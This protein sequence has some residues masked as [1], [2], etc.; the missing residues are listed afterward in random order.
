MRAFSA[1]LLLL[2]GYCN[3]VRGAPPSDVETTLRREVKSYRLSGVASIEALTRAASE[4]KIP[5]GIE[6]FDADGAKQVNVSLDKTT[7]R[8]LVR[9]I[10]DSIG[11]YEMRPDGDILHIYP[12]NVFKDER[13]FLNIRLKSFESKND[14]VI[15]ANR[16]F[17]AQ[18]RMIVAPRVPADTGTGSAG[19]V[20]TGLGDKRVDLSLKDKTVRDVL[21]ALS[22]PAD[23]KVWIVVHSSAAPLTRGGYWRSRFVTREASETE[24][25]PVWTL[26]RWGYDPINNRYRDASK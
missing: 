17:H 19:S 13:N 23:Y 15:T 2:L 26:I 24:S 7:V 9:A 3:A 10:L 8:D 14:F 20:A 6:L 5:M 12:R 25:Q 1:T 11:S 21:D 18:V 16:R 22:R 4:F